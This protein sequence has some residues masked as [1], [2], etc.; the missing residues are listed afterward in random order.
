MVLGGGVRVKEGCGLEDL[1]CFDLIIALKNFGF[2]TEKFKKVRAISIPFKMPD[3]EICRVYRIVLDG[4][5]RYWVPPQGKITE[6]LFIPERTAF[7]HVIVTP[8]GF[9]AGILNVLF[10]N[11]IAIG[12]IGETYTLLALR[13]H[14]ERL[15]PLF[16]EKSIYVWVEDEESD[17]AEKVAKL[18][19]RE[20]K[21]FG[22]NL[23]R[24]YKDAYR[25]VSQRDLVTARRFILELMEKAKT[26]R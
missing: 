5:T 2:A 1:L 12:G 14:K 8:S 19:N 25:I 23:A 17:F 9:D 16:K 11:T 3:G 21:A 20:V 24:A 15:D 22:Q 13:A 6:L 7:E 4:K 18:F 10:A 26:V